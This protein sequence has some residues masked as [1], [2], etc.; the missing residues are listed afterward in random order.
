M[1]KKAK[2]GLNLLLKIALAVGLI[3]WF[4][5]KGLL[6]LHSVSSLLSPWP[7]FILLLAAFLQVYFN[8][9]RWFFLLRAHALA[10]SIRATFSL[11]FIGLFFNYAMPGGVGGDVIKGY[12]LLQDYPEQKTAG[13]VSIFMDRMIGFSVM[14]FTAALALLLHWDRVQRSAEFKT[15]AG[16]VWLLSFGF[17]V[18]YVLALSKTLHASQLRK[19][20]FLKIPLG[21]HIEKVYILT[22]SYRNHLKTLQ[23]SFLL[24]FVSQFFLIGAVA[25]IGFWLGYEHLSFSDY[26]FIVPLGTVVMALPISPAG[27]G[28]GQAAFYFLFNLY[29]GHTTTLGPTAATA[30]QVSQLLWG[31]VGAL[32][33]LR[34]KSPQHEV[35][36]A[37]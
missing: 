35:S 36:H 23:V 7:A 25:F 20:V 2:Q 16:A 4:I 5:H 29:L 27:I 10:I 31:L 17:I 3:S 8:N 33:Y 19:K 30:L 18:F 26:A 14:I 22:H 28:V 11:S 32:F 9:L 34:R 6:D 21:H 12:Y 37:S 15:L 24:S 1:G 13:I